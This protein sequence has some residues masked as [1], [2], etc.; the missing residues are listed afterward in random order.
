M[1]HNFI[2][3]S[4]DGDFGCFYCP[5]Y[6]KQCCN[7][8]CS[9]CLSGLWFS[10]DMCPLVGLQ[11]HMVVLFLVFK[12]NSMLFSIVTVS[13]YIPT[14]SV[15]GFPFLHILS[16]IYC[17][18]IF[19]HDDHSDWYGGDT[20]LLLVFLLISFYPNPH[21]LAPFFL[22]SLVFSHFYLSVDYHV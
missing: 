6:C 14:N 12:G 9:A 1:Y 8:H 10:Q 15:R 7:E 22:A 13:I 21:F 17:L 20:S 5:V 4:V 3:S 11:G 18:Q 16:S 19:F 2:H